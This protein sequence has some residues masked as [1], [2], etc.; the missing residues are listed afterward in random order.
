M[1]KNA[2]LIVSTLLVVMILLAATLTS[3]PLTFAQDDDEGSIAVLLPDSRSSDRWEND[4]RRFLEAA[5]E[6]AEV[7]F[8]IVNAEGDAQTQL[9]QAEQAITAGA[10]VL[11]MVNLDSAS[12]ATIIELARENGVAIIDYDRLT[13]EGPGADFYVS[14][15]G[16]AV[17]VIQG[18]GIVAAVEEAGLENPRVAVLNGSP[19]DNNATLFKNGY[20]SI[21]NPL[22]ESGEWIEVDDQSV[23][24]WDNQEALLIFEQMLTAAEGEIDAAVAANDGLGGAVIAALE[25]AGLPFIPV[26]GQDA[27]VG[28]IQNIL[29]GRQSMTVYKAIRAQA[30]AAAAL[31]IALLRGEDTDELVTSEVNNGTSDI[32]SLLLVPVSVTADN[33]AETVIEDGFRTWEEICVGEFE[34][35]CPPEDER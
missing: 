17:G 33:I 28:G 21:I 18:E 30:E 2:R 5:F 13:I 11:L 25:N 10:R 16:E 20:D 3:A 9:T 35:F 24:D 12:G 15:D 29:A 27:T 31:A 1:N 22:F 19:T 14:F 32:P 23:P 6:E 26:T 34:E 8:S 4:D 7:E